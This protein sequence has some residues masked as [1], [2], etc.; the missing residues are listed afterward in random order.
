MSVKAGQKL[1]G[2]HHLE[3]LRLRC[4]MCGECWLWRG[5]LSNRRGSGKPSVS[6]VV[7]GKRQAMQGRRAS[8]I[9]AGIKIRADHVVVP[10]ANCVEAMCINP[11]HSEAI[12]ISEHRR[13]IAL[14]CSW[15]TRAEKVLLGRKVRD[16]ALAKLTPEQ[17]LNIKGRSDERSD[18]LAA[19]FGVSRNTIND[20][21][22]GRSW[23]DIGADNLVAN[24]SV[25]AWR[26]AA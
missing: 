2:V 19:E 18:A 8:L 4:V 21:R 12:S 5:A 24:A 22:R 7:N 10:K 11:A 26:P 6:V 1:H 13:R 23:R 3:D 15:K 14:S 20:I 17:V 16:T 25:F 9:F